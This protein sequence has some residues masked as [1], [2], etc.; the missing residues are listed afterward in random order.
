MDLRPQ[1]TAQTRLLA[2]EKMLAHSMALLEK[3]NQRCLTLEQARRHLQTVLDAVPFVIGYWDKNQINQV[4]NKAHHGR[5]GVAAADIPG[6][7]LEE[8]LSPEDYK[9]QFGRVQAALA[10]MPQTYEY[11]QVD[12]TTGA[13]SHYLGQYL[14]DTSKTGVRGFM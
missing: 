13:F 14:P 6:M 9:E 7:S 5:F 12:E 8:L 1:H 10:G 2:Q 3:N 4:A 11:T